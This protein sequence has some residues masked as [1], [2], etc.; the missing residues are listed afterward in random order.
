MRLAHSPVTLSA[1]KGLKRQI[2]RYAGAAFCLR[3][4]V[5]NRQ[6]PTRIGFG[7]PT[8]LTGKVRP[9]PDGES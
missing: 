6:R 7:D 8:K 5:I 4:K 3:L 1:A 2:L 9:L